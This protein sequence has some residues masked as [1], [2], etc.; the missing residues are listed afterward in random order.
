MTLVAEK[1][2]EISLTDGKVDLIKR[3]YCKNC[4]NDEIE[5]FIH[6]CKKTGLDPI[7]KQIYAIKRGGVLTIQTGID[8]L[9]LIAERTA[10]YSPGR[11]ST[12]V[13]DEKN[14]LISATSYIKKRTADN[15]W[16]EVAACAYFD[17]FNAKQ[18]LW[19]K[20]PRV[21][22]AKCAEAHAL[23][24]AFPAEMSGLYSSEEME[25]AAPEL[26]SSSRTEITEQ[27]WA[28]MDSLVMDIKDEEYLKKLA[29]FVKV[30]TLSNIQPK[31]YDRVMRSLN[32]YFLENVKPRELSNA[33][34]A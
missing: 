18:G 26:P 4:T 19:Q 28:E 20:M 3:M 8:G 24:K 17:E 16:H 13:Y 2:H 33:A 10:N 6:A 29:D 9:R 30:D 22:L 23:R 34:T 7:S 1:K 12:F 25:Q 32:R 14:N 31:D 21:M 15:T 5:I 27:E 11:E